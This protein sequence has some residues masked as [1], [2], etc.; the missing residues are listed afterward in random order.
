MFGPSPIKPI[1]QHIRKA[2]QC[3]K[4]LYPFF[5]AV[6]KNDW[7]TANKIKDKIIAIEKEAD[8]IKRDLRLHLP[9]GLFLPVA[10][11]DILELLSAQDRIA[12]KAEDIAALIISR[13]MSIPKKLIPS[14]MPFLNR[15]LDASKQACTAINELDEL[16]ETGFRGSEVKIV[17]EMIVKLDEI[18]HDCDERLADIRHKIFELEKELPA[19]DVIFLYKLVQWIGELADH[20]QTVG[21]RL[22]ILIA[23]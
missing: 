23:R 22:Q 12:N 8:L 4:Q 17:E 7:D 3:A 10:R 9:T 11:T 16:L 15:C 1:E 2:H 21:G 19:I 14:F 20:A 13:Q 18:E 5:E 6:L